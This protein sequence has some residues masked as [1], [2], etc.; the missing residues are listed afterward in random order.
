MDAEK[1]AIICFKLILIKMKS[2][3]ILLRKGT[4]TP[5]PPLKG[6]EGTASITL[7]LSGVPGMFHR[8]YVGTV[9]GR[10]VLRYVEKRTRL[11]EA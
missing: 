7:P 8:P 9:E 3:M 1:A 2:P 10:T 5:G 11:T 6:Q 4:S